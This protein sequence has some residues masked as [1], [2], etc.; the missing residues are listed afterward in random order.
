VAPLF[1][2]LSH[3]SRPGAAQHDVDP[4]VLPRGRSAGGLAVPAD[5]KGGL[6]DAVLHE[7]TSHRIGS[8]QREPLVVAGGARGVGV[9]GH[10]DCAGRACFVR[11][12]RESQYFFTGWVQ[13]GA[14]MV[15]VDCV[16]Y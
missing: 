10:Q 16:I 4:A 7:H 1:S 13:P 11:I 6:R 2:G 3:R 9:P 12:G 5:H 15:E 8:P 14:V